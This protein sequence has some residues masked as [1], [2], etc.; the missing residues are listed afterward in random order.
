MTSL[1]ALNMVPHGVVYVICNLNL[2]LFLALPEK[3]EFITCFGSDMEKG[4]ENEL[5]EPT[6]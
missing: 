1:M 4:Y 3:I 5:Q 6:M 2:W